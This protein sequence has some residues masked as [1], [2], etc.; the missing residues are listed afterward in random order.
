MNHPFNKEDLARMIRPTSDEA[1]RLN[2]RQRVSTATEFSNNVLSNGAPSLSFETA[3]V[4]D[5]PVIVSKDLYTR[6][7]LASLDNYL[8][9]ALRIS[10]S[11]RSF[12]CRHIVSNLRSNCD[13]HIVRSDVHSFFESISVESLLKN[14]ACEAQVLPS[15]I[16]FLRSILTRLSVE[17]GTLGLPRGLALSSTLSEYYIKPIDLYFQRDRRVALYSRYVDDIFIVWRGDQNE[18]SACLKKKL[19]DLGL[20]LNKKKTVC[21]PCIEGS[22]ATFLGYRFELK[23]EGLVLSIAPAKLARLK[24]RIV[25]ALWCFSRD[26]NFSL[27]RDRLNFLSRVVSLRKKNR[28]K[29]VF[30]GI[31]HN[32]QLANPESMKIQLK[33][34]DRFMHSVIFSRRYALSRQIRSRLTQENI[35]GLKSFSFESSFEKR[36]IIS[37]QFERIAL[38]RK[39]WSNGI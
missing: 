15:V 7:V 27:L 2:R 25:R 34:V 37:F 20:S 1:I 6:T 39:A 4:K 24:T 23:T 22:S 12:E 9:R 21:V 36:A 16:D 31:A 3:T 14:L 13:D 19:S 5:K 33:E 11:D 18:S 38:I 28:R 8:R 10:M 35:R 32:Y 30:S 26:G 17:F 29:E